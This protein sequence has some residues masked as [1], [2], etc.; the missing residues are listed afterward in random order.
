[1][2]ILT[3]TALGLTTAQLR[4]AFAAALVA[5]LLGTSFAAAAVV[6]KGP[7]SFWALA[8]A[9]VGYNAGL[10]LALILTFLAAR[11]RFRRILRQLGL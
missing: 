1:M 9:V 10:V 3:A 4:S 6:S 2:I 7:V 11:L 8:S 5:F